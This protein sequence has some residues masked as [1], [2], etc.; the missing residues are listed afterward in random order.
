MFKAI[1]RHQRLKQFEDTNV[2]CVF[3]WKLNKVM[4]K[5]GV[6][7]PN[8]KGFMADNTQANWNVMQI[9]YGNGDPTKPMINKQQT[10]YFH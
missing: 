4:L 9:A 7:N 10:C 2:Q 8:F 3:G 1:W 5:K 6:P